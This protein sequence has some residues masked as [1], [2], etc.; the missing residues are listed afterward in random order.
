MNRNLPISNYLEKIVETVMENDVVIIKAETGSGKSTQ[1]PQALYEYGYEII[2]TQPRRVA[3][4]NVARRVAEE[5]RCQLGGLV[6]YRTG[7]ERLDS[8]ETK[9]LFCTDGLE[10]A[11]ELSQKEQNV[12]RI[13]CIDEVHEWNLNIEALI[14]W[15]KKKIQEG[16]AS[17]VV[18]MSATMD[19][20]ALQKYFFDCPVFE[21]P[22]T[23]YSVKFSEIDE[24]S[25]FS[26]LKS[27]T[28]QNKN[29]LVFQPGKNEIYDFI[30][31]Y[32]EIEAEF[33]PL[34]G[35][36]DVSEQ[37]AC[38]DNYE[39]SKIIVATNIAQTSITIPDIDVVI[40]FGTEKR[41]ELDA[42]I[43][44]L[45]KRNISQSDCL[46]RKGRA[47]RVKNGQYYLVSDL[48][49]DYRPEFSKPEIQRLRI[50]SVILKFLAFGIDMEEIELF[51]EVS[52]TKIHE[53][54]KL[55]ETLGAIKDGKITEI[56]KKM[57][58][59]PLEV[60][61]SRMLI[62][63]ENRG[64]LR[65]MITIVSI[66]QIG[67]FIKKDG[68]IVTENSRSDL[69]NHMYIFNMLEK[70]YFQTH[71]YSF[72]CFREVNL[73]NYKRIV[74]LRNKI[75]CYYKS[76]QI[77]LTTS[78]DEDEI[79]K[80]ILAGYKN[81]IFVLEYYQQYEGK[82]NQYVKLDRKSVCSGEILIGKPRNIIVKS[83]FGM[84]RT[85]SLLT[86]CSRVSIDMLEEFCP[87]LIETRTN[88]FEYDEISD[89]LCA[90]EEKYVFGRCVCTKE[91]ITTDRKNVDEYIAEMLAFQ[92]VGMGTIQ[93]K[94]L[95][96]ICS[97]NS[98]SDYYIAKNFYL[99]AI[100]GVKSIKDL[101]SN[102]QMMRDIKKYA[103]MGDLFR[104]IKIG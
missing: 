67:S 76:N 97:Y 101:L 56:G 83:D 9:I 75:L 29:V 19:T 65:D 73:K 80:S 53:S 24:R 50:E 84:N 71:D 34:H 1:I 93:N 30:K 46:Q 48:K 22:G 100:K 81:N 38:F 13:L 102:S 5:M 36:L 23:N 12:D 3:V 15:C 96:E 87:E 59:M 35:E 74:E 20:T 32:K 58:R 2:V 66:L 88:K 17:K 25:V 104:N 69:L 82:N 92:S 10:L 6:G 79:I 61:L 63:A 62:E 86:M 21:V 4:R 103:D 91:V 14:A 40:D 27:L 70:E 37:D 99:N 28:E 57:S 55:L 49:F 26:V 85:L 11:K 44:G 16:F 39:K 31:E 51:H 64:V 98:F 78:S 47:G 95:R 77:M 72:T 89:A 18:I 42:G 54:K 7:F 41:L 68:Y 94:V 90:I 8:E 60:E 52:K 43:E 33:L 45:Y